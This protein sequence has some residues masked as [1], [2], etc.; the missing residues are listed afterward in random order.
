[1]SLGSTF[2]CP[3]RVPPN[4]SVLLIFGVAHRLFGMG[5]LHQFLWLAKA[6]RLSSDWGL[7]LP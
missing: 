2:S 5:L 7:S 1:L 3:A 4:R 6:K